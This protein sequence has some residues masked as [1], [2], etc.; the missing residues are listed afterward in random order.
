MALRLGLQRA[1]RASAASRRV[2][3]RSLSSFQHAADKFVVEFPEEHDGL[4]IEF[5]WSLADD[6]VTPHG[7]AYRNL[8]W[9]K[10][11]EFAKDAKPAGKAVKVQEVD[12]EVAFAEYEAVFE[13][14][15]GYLSQQKNL[16]AQDGAVG[17]F[18]DNRTR[19]RVI[20]DSPVVALFAQNLLVRVPT[21]DPHAARPIVVYVASEGEFKGQEPKAY[22]LLDK[23]EDDE[24]FVK[25]VVT[26]AA[27]LN[28]VKD[29]IALAKKKLSEQTDAESLVLPGDVLLKAD[30]SALV[31]NASGATRAQNINAGSLYAAHGNIWSA[32]GLTSLFG[33]AVVDAGKV[34]KKQVVATE[35]GAAVHVPCNNLV[36][37]PKAAFFVTKSSGVKPISAE[38]ASE[39]LKKVDAGVDAEKFAALLKQADTKAFTVGSEADIDAALAKL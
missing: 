3:T 15:T 7:D 38:Q 11:A 20:S 28:S 5:N 8:Q 21:K 18:K 2:V 23:N 12:V 14:V 33:G 26:G 25:V 30:K 10:L 34:Q 6:D 27:D 29:A 1:L 4:N 9:A 39:L 36:D 32:A 31:F 37:A 35:A 17:S 24:V 19:V 16:F 22:L 13:K